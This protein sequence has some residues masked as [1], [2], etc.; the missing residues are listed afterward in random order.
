VTHA[1]SLAPCRH[2]LA[3]RLAEAGHRG[4]ALETARE[5][6]D[7]YRSLARRRPETFRQGLADTLGT[8]A[9]VLQWVGKDSDA[10]RIRQESE[11]VTEQMTLKTSV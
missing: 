3:K 6:V 9:S 4:E 5:A 1:P 11:D 2:R 8:Y 10:A 7:L